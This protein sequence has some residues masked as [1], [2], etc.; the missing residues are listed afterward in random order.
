[1]ITR[2][3]IQSVVETETTKTRRIV[4]TRRKAWLA[5]FAISGL[6]WVVVALIIWHL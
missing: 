2:L 5:A 4:S 1:M 3:S 6:F